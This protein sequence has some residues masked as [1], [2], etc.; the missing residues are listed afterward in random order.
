MGMSLRSFV[1]SYFYHYW[2]VLISETALVQSELLNQV[3]LRDLR[4]TN[5]HHDKD[6]IQNTN[7]G[8]L[9]ELY[10]WILYNEEFQEWQNDQSN[11]LLWIRD[12]SGK[13]KTMFLYS[14]IEEFTR[15]I[16]YISN[17]V[18]FFCQATD[19]RINNATAVLC[20]LIYL[21]VLKQSSFLFYL[22]SYYD[23][24]GKLLFENINVWSVFS[25]IFIEIV[26]DPIL[27]SIYLIIDALDEYTTD[28]SYLLELIIQMLSVYL[29][30]KWIVSSRNWSDIEECF[31]TIQ[32]APILLEF[33]EVS[34][35][36]TVSKFIQYKINKLAKVKKYNN[37]TCYTIY[38]YLLS[39]LQNTFFWIVLVCQEL[40][41]ILRRYTLERFI[42]FFSG[43]NIL[44]GRI[45][46]QVRNSE[47][48]KICK[49]ILAVISTV[50]RSIIF[51]KFVSFVELSDNFSDDF[52]S[53]SDIIAICG[54]F[55]TVYKDTII[56]VHQSAKDF[57]LREI[58]DWYLSGGI[59]TEYFRI[60]FCFLQTIFKIFRY[61]IFQFKFS[62]F[63]IENIIPLCPNPLA[64]AEYLYLYWIYYLQNGCS[65]KEN[66][67]SLDEDICVDNFLQQKYLHWLEIFSILGNIFRGIEAIL[68]LVDLLE[69]SP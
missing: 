6:R 29:Q 50:Y 66:D 28:L 22:Q 12:N 5:P 47:D 7:G 33:N 14:I 57:F 20:G 52:V 30:L 67:I 62:G 35:S 53:V 17:I 16:G 69:I 24:A 60:F 10:C 13:G 25:K 64:A 39:N 48:T 42:I 59:E 65:D 36:E 18:F 43:L 38:H 21:F 34:V 44:Y 68:I 40:D 49:R 46:D 31:D 2:T 26:R 41:R 63:S 4:T 27:R 56:F 37:K 11:C 23:Q 45:I 9:K 55:L 61:N 58:R 54:L 19:K 32:A 15:T 51:H 8:L 3:C 1:S